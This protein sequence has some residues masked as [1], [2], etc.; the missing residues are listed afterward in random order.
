MLIIKKAFKNLMIQSLT[1]LFYLFRIFPIKKNKIVIKNFDGKGYGDN[2]KYIVEKIIKEN[3]N[4]EL[5]W[6]VDDLNTYMNKKIKKVKN[7]SLR[8]VYELCTAKIWID[9]SRKLYFVRKRKSQVYIQTWHGA[10]A[11]KQIEGQVVNKLPK[12][13]VKASK[14]DSKMIDILLSNSKWTTRLMRK[15][16]WYDGK[17]LECG[18]PRNDILFNKDELLRE[19]ICKSINVD[20]DKKYILYAPTFRNNLS[21]DAYNLNI[22]LLCRSLGKYWGG[23]WKVL[24]R[25]H[26][27]MANKAIDLYKS[28]NVIDVTNYPDIS[29]L[30]SISELLITDYSSCLFDA[31]FALKK[32]VIYASDIDEYMK[33]RGTNFEFKDLPFPKAKNN[34]E[35]EEIIKSFNL[36]KYI[37]E[38][39]IF[40]NSLEIFEDGCGSEVV[41]KE[42]RKILN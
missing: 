3:L 42:I 23:D 35:L 1:I 37:K 41:C 28:E 2:P 30:I 15:Y 14:N 27:I 13:W 34:N 4:C 21:L 39:K 7:N 25:L 12:T 5:V 11:L 29:E 10:V 24:I 32:V 26:P 31:G 8:E 22:N 36:N 33:D 9:N 19:N 18:T 40:N 16:F 6:I 38:V 17:I 20:K